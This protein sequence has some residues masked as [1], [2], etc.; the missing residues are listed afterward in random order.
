MLSRTKVKEEITSTKKAL[1]SL[2]ETIKR[3]E[4]GISINKIVLEGFETYLSS[5]RL[6]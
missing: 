6:Q 4:D 2:K 3:C 5:L 1:E